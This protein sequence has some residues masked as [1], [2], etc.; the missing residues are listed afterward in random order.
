MDSQKVVDFLERECEWRGGALHNKATGRRVRAILPV[1]VLGHPI[2][3][4][5]ILAVARKYGL[6]VVED[7]TEGL[8]AKYRDR[9]VGHLGDVACFSFN[10]NKIVTTGGG[11]MLVTNNEAWA[12]KAKYLTT[13]AKDDPIEYVHNEIGYNYRLT[14]IQA[15]MGCAQMERLE[16]HI[17]AKRWIAATYAAA[18]SDVP[19][20]TPM[21]EAGWAFSTFWMYTLLVDG[22]KQGL[23][24]RSLLRRLAERGIQARPLW[25]PIHLGPA[26][27]R[28]IMTDCSVAERLSREALC[29]PC[30]VGM[31][32]DQLTE[33]IRVIAGTSDARTGRGLIV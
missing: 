5:P 11:G 14:N 17:S 1:H 32:D 31:S 19:G 6:V 16:E 20:I 29:L 12:Q 21:R 25:R 13:Q 27:R 33:V 18:F 24:S 9:M 10:G 23:E 8:G 7:A 2:D 15:A 28:A 4:D 3:A 30:S 22:S 26:H